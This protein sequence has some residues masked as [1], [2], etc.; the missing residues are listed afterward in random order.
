MDRR[1]FLKK[2]ASIGAITAS[3]GIG[4]SFAR[5]EGSTPAIG[6]RWS[7]MAMTDLKPL[8]PIPEHIAAVG[9]RGMVS[10]SH[11]VATEAAL[12][13]LERGGTAADAYIT[14]AFAQVVL[15]PTMTTLGGGWWIHYFDAA[16]NR[17]HE[18]TS[19]FATPAAAKGSMS[20]ADTMTGRAVMVPGWVRGAELS[21]KKWG[22]L[23]WAELLEPA[24]DIAENGLI[25][26]HL[27][28]GWTFEKKGL[29]GRYPEGREI[30]FPNGYMLGVG[31]TLRQPHLA[32]TL[33]RLKDEGPDYFYTGRWAKNM[34]AAVR[35]RGSRITGED[36][37]NYQPGE[38]TDGWQPGS[39]DGLAATTFRGYEVGPPS[40]AM[41]GLGF[42]LV[43]AGDLRS[44]GRPS[45]NADSLYLL[46]RIMQEMWHTGLQYNTKT[47][48]K[49]VS[50]EYAEQLWPLIENGP[51]RP[52]NGFDAGTCALA[53][54]DSEGNM[55]SGDH[56]ISSSIY[57]TGI[58]V[59]GVV[60]N[61]VL[62][63]IKYDFPRGIATS[64]WLFKGG[65][66]VLTMASPSVAFTECVLQN[67]TNVVEYGMDLHESVLQP[68]FGHTDQ[69]FGGTQIEGSFSEEIL[70]EVEKRGMELMRT[71]PWYVYMGS[72][73]G[74]ML[75]QQNGTIT[76]VADP[77]RR[78]MAKGI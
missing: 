9:R 78:G 19:A 39:N 8:A 50:K 5:E 42:N 16:K 29:V 73:Q 63:N 74:V 23:S 48:D 25:I 7:K 15:E 40:L 12:W 57:G 20:N 41:F 67:V 36:L 44:R 31:D 70:Q 35:A 55:A 21:H 58:F 22:R 54:V 64:V 49:L 18:G 37:R 6:G 59:D 69:N 46:I 14:A 32:M 52:F 10:S 51:P 17:L 24:I 72:C 62:Y 33:K 56:S 30:W 28:W 1:D 11:P 4:A 71:S 43:E 68:R 3:G 76:G 53:I 13:A 61:R 26:D 34:V 77:R 38:F 2:A 66:P 60:L 45:D 65:K 47:H 75:N 27:L